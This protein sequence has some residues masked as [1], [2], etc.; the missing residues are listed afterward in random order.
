MQAHSSS[1]KKKVVFAKICQNRLCTGNKEY[2]LTRRVSALTS[3][4]VGVLFFSRG[5]ADLESNSV[6]F[7]LSNT[8][9]CL[10]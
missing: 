9:L 4:S 7:V 2:Y 1:Y 6:D 10:A 8:L 3:I 5:K